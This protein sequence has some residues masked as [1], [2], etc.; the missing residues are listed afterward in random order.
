ML[1]WIA[2]SA[3]ELGGAGV[4]VLASRRSRS[5]DRWRDEF[6]A[7]ARTLH[8]RPS[9]GS[10][11]DAPQLRAEIDGRAVTLRASVDGKAANERTIAAEIALADAGANLRFVLEAGACEP[12][13]GFEHIPAV[14]FVSRDHAKATL[15]ADDEPLARRCIDDA[16]VDFFDAEREAAAR[17]LRLVIRGGHLTL[18]LFRARAEARAIVRIARVAVRVAGIAERPHTTAAPRSSETG[19]V[20]GTL[21]CGSCGAPSEANDV[22]WLR[23]ARCGTT[24]HAAC[25]RN[26]TGCVRDSCDETRSV[27]VER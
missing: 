20:G 12:L 3:L 11:S 13:G 2:L 10:A 1:E 19:I 21:T 15:R 4:A 6:E 8:G 23:C 27:E 25:F 26:A 9:L 5:R 16:A 14:E 7:A 22:A 24:Y 17:G 18:S